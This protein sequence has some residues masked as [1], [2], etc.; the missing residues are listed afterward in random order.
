VWERIIDEST[1][2]SLGITVDELCKLTAQESF[3]RRIIKYCEENNIELKHNMKIDSTY[4][5]STINEEEFRASNIYIYDPYNRIRPGK[6]S[7]TLTEALNTTKYIT[8]FAGPSAYKSLFMLVRVYA[9]PDDVKTITD[10][11]K[12]IRPSE[13]QKDRDVSVTSY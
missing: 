5:L 1:A 10:I 7:F 2:E 3:I 6:K 11:W 4:K 9:H 8:T 12:K 13:S